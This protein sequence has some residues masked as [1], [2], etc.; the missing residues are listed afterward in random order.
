MESLPKTIRYLREPILAI[1][2]ED[3]DLLGEGEADTTLLAQAIKQQ[4]S[5]HSEGFAGEHAEALERWL[6][7][8]ATPEKGWAA[9]AWFVQAFLM[10]Y[11][12]FDMEREQGQ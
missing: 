2:D 9:P 10:G 8:V 3:Q 5:M 7:D 11:E 12:M 1:A 4:G 6:Q